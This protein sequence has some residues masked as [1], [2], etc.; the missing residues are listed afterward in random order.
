[1]QL[2]E[3]QKLLENY[4]IN[5]HPQDTNE[6]DSQMSTEDSFVQSSMNSG[7]DSHDK[8]KN[9]NLYEVNK[10]NM[11]TNPHVNVKHHRGNEVGEIQADHGNRTQDVSTIQLNTNKGRGRGRGRNRQEHHIGE[12]ALQQKRP[13]HQDILPTEDFTRHK[14]HNTMPDNVPETIRSTPSSKS[15]RSTKYQDSKKKSKNEDMKKM[16][17]YEDLSKIEEALEVRYIMALLIE[18]AK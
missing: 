11:N 8:M 13:D 16:I 7:K 9:T 3:A 18:M 6:S 12:D 1:M 15:S 14:Q 10:H 2:L 17:V 5:D 4:H